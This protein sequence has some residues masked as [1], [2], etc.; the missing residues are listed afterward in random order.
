V[1]YDDF[2]FGIDPRGN[3][4]SRRGH[5]W[6]LHGEDGNVLRA[7]PSEMHLRAAFPNE[8]TLSWKYQKFL[9]HAASQRSTPFS[10][11]AGSSGGGLSGAISS[12]FFVLR[13]ED[14]EH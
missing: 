2:T 9:L 4:V 5:T 6:V 8:Q 7:S 11:A 14:E 13:P 1:K 10:A 3:V 12:M